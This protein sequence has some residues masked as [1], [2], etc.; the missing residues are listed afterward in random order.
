MNNRRLF[1]L[2]GPHTCSVHSA[3]HGARTDP[4]ECLP[5]NSLSSA[6]QTFPG[7][8]PRCI[9]DD[10]FVLSVPLAPRGD[11]QDLQTYADPLPLT[12]RAC[13]IGTATPQ[14]APA[15][16]GS[17]ALGIRPYSAPGTGRFVRRF[18]AGFRSSLGHYHLGFLCRAGYILGVRNVSVGTGL[19]ARHNRTFQA[20][21][22]YWIGDK[23]QRN[24]PLNQSSYPP[25]LASDALPHPPHEQQQ[26]ACGDGPNTAPGG[27]SVVRTPA[28]DT[29]RN[30]VL[31]H[32]IAVPH[33]VR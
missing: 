29:R 22:S 17:S 3:L 4:P 18:H 9:W 31:G 8:S 19:P 2:I 33:M 7:P 5:E 26:Q 28:L 13:F 30:L 15:S 20:A 24:H 27:G 23:K 12:R 6:D 11:E 16:S 1:Q 10:H 32:K 21:L 14:N 25:F